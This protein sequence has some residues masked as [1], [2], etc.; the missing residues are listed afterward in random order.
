[1]YIISTHVRTVSKILA[2]YKLK[3]LL[4]YVCTAI[5]MNIRTYIEIATGLIHMNCY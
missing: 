1:M 4:I 5:V 2:L 3:L